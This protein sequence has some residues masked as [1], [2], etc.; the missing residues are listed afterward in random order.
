V[1][2]YLG[3][4]VGQ[5][6]QKVDVRPPQYVLAEIGLGLLAAC[7]RAKEKSRSTL[8]GS[9]KHRHTMVSREFPKRGAVDPSALDRPHANPGEGVGPGTQAFL[10]CPFV[11]VRG[12]L[13]RL[14]NAGSDFIKLSYLALPASIVK[15][16]K[17]LQN[18]SNLVD[19]I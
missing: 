15:F 19:Q 9:D 7:S 13:P 17:W 3:A 14:H 11:R 10:H 18:S 6:R 1:P 12:I 8:V 16:A 4:Y 2:Q 5:L